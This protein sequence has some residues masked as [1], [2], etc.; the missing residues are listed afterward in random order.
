M[1]IAGMKATEFK[2]NCPLLCGG[3]IE[4]EILMY[5]LEGD[6]LYVYG[7]CGE[8]GQSGNLMISLYTLLSRTPTS[9]VM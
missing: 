5:L 2:L 4:N 8:C 6:Q 7:K 9:V 1:T 3:Y